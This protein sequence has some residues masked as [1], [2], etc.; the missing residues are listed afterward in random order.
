MLWFC[1]TQFSLDFTL[2]KAGTVRVPGQLMTVANWSL[3]KKDGELFHVLDQSVFYVLS[4]YLSEGKVFSASE[5]HN[6]VLK[7]W[8][9]SPADILVSA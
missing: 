4:K 9:L 5:C 1:S 7:N 6:Q 2:E 3:G 8:E